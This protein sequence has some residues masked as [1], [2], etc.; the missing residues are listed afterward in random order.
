MPVRLYMDQHV[1][2][3][4]TAGL[5]LRC[6]D[7]LTAFEDGAALLSDQE[8]LDRASLSDRILFSQDDDL[9]AEATR[10]Q[11]RGLQFA[12]VVYAHPLSVSIGACIHSLEIVAKA[13]KPEDLRDQVLFLPI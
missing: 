10:R 7:V 9:L 12:G 13:G 8:L 3:A 5:R 6:V 4:I 11:A 2:R 1:P